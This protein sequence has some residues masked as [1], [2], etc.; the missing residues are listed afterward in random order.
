M[1]YNFTNYTRIDGSIADYEK[2]YITDQ[3]KYSVGLS[4]RGIPFCLVQETSII[5]APRS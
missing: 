3:N 2:E 1:K 4:I 5:P